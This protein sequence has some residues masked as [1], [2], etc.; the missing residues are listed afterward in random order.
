MKVKKCIIP[1][2]G[3]GTR[4]LPVTK[5]VSK[6]MLPILNDPTIMLIVKECLK[7][8]IEEVIFVT[9]K[10]NYKLI[11]EF[12]TKNDELEDFIK[13]NSNKEL[14][15][16]LNEI[17]DK[18][19]FN[20]IIQDENIRGT[21][22]ALYAAK[23]YINDEYFGVIFGDDLIDSS[24]PMLKDLID[25]S[26]KY[27]CNVIGVR[28]I[29]EKYKNY[30]YVVKYKEDNIMEKFAKTKEEKVDASK[31]MMLGRLVLNSN[32]FDKLLETKVH[33]NN[34]YFLPDALEILD[35]EIRCVKCSGKYYNIG[36]I[37]G[38]IKANIAYGLKNDKIRLEIENFVNEI[39]HKEED[40]KNE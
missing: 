7:S 20:Y 28:E 2:A 11:K 25:E 5:T 23:D 10:D 6:E 16:D 12:F 1:I 15:N 22:G 35:E 34:E 17:I 29:E 9:N 18:I 33:D 13:N 8:G 19:K 24:K 4:R 32:I 37:E 26:E 21:S 14:L 39:I 36:N 27:N 38:F 40:D 31:D 30:Y 3:K